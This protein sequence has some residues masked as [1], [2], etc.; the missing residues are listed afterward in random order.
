MNALAEVRLEQAIQDVEQ[1]L[2]DDTLSSW[3]RKRLHSALGDLAAMRQLLAMEE[4]LRDATT[5]PAPASA[6]RLVK[7]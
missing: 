7:P 4:T 3:H 5:L 2:V 6:L 1:V